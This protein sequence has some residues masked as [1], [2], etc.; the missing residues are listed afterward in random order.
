MHMGTSKTD[1]T[2]S[3]WLLL[4]DCGLSS[5]SALGRT[6]PRHRRSHPHHFGSA[7]PST[8]SA[9]DR[10]SESSALRFVCDRLKGR[11]GCYSSLSRGPSQHYPLNII[12]IPVDQTEY[13]SVGEDANVRP[14]SFAWVRKISQEILKRP[15]VGLDYR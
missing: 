2:V 6:L 1:S 14:A 7:I 10:A 11:T 13:R 9:P 3:E 12:P 15:L 8:Y 4:A 5:P